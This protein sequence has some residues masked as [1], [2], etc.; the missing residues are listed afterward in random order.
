MISVLHV[1]CTI[2]NISM[3]MI[4]YQIVRYIMITQYTRGSN[5][6]L[7]RLNIPT[8]ITGIWGQAE[9]QYE[10]CEVKMTTPTRRNSYS[11]SHS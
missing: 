10:S 6:P 5:Y 4:N 1:I 2:Y 7:E 3:G 11:T 8:Y 9:S